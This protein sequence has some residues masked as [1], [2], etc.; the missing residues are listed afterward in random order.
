V[1]LAE[2]ITHEALVTDLVIA[3]GIAAVPSSIAAWAAISANKKVS[4]NGSQLNIG[5][6]VEENAARTKALVESVEQ[7]HSNMRLHCQEEHRHILASQSI[8]PNCG[9]PT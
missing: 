9:E 7:H 2:I 3:A 1:F 4:T 8:C 5:M 6:L